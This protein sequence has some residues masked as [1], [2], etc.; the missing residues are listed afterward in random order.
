MGWEAGVAGVRDGVV[1]VR[2]GGGAG[3]AGVRDRVAGGRGGCERRGGGQV[4]R[5]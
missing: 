2:R 4:W 1:G 3:V 5:V